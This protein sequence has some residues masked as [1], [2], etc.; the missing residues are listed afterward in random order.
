MRFATEYM[1]FQTKKRREFIN[2]TE[3][4]RKVVRGSGM[5]EG[6]LVSAMHIT[7]GVWINDAESGL[8]ADVEEWLETLA[9]TGQYWHKTSNEDGALEVQHREYRHHRS[10]EDNGDAHFN[11]QVTITSGI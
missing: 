10:G 2:I 6:V 1:T 3:D 5:R 4:V 8:L 7:S 9:P 11:F